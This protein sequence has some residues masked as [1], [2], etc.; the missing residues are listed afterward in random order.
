MKKVDLDA[1]EATAN[2]AAA[3]LDTRPVALVVRKVVKSAKEGFAVAAHLMAYEQ[4]TIQEKTLDQSWLL[5]GLQRTGDSPA[6]AT[7]SRP[8][9]GGKVYATGVEPFALSPADFEAGG[10]LFAHE[11]DKSIDVGAEFRRIYADA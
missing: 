6:I 4:M 11:T 8:K 5:V 3:A 7:I 9:N 2:E 1:L 10:V